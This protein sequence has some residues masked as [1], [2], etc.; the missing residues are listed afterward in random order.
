MLN[1]PLGAGPSAALA[2]A[3][4]A[5]SGYLL[6]PSASTAGS[7]EATVE[8]TVTGQAPSLVPGIVIKITQVARAPV[9]QFT[10]P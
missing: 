4:S 1:A 7:S 9:E 6:A 10:T 2:F 3:R 8:V 5:A